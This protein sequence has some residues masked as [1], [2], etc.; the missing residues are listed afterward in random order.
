M[1]LAQNLRHSY[2]NQFEIVLP[3]IDCK[4]KE[5]IV[6]LGKSGTGKST[7]LHI[8]S[9]LLRPTHGKVSIDGTDIFSLTEAERDIFRK[10]NIGIV[11]Q[12][13]IFI[14]SL[15]A[16]ENLNF[17]LK[18]AT[19]FSDNKK[20]LN[21]ME[22]LGLGNKSSSLVN[23]LSQGELQRLSIIRAMI[24]QPKLVLADEPSSALDD[25]NAN[26]VIQLLQEQ[27]A[28]SSAAL[29]IVTHDSRL[30]TMFQKQITI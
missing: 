7:L 27:A 26:I 23:N 15:T 11:L 21:W 9:G 8:L 1:L 10:K 14:E 30:K 16:L 3:D 4:N 22:S 2:A 19:G 29:V 25:D 6:I 12:K 28:I 13:H 17:F 24:H 20:C 5:G 18:T